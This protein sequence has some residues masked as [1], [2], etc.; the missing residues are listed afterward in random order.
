MSALTDT[1]RAEKTYTFAITTNPFTETNFVGGNIVTS[2]SSD[3]HEPFMSD[4]SNGSK[5]EPVRKVNIAG[6]AE[7]T[8]TIAVFLAGAYQTSKNQFLGICF[9]PICEPDVLPSCVG[10]NYAR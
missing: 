9:I 5:P 1:L 10:E 2:D 4:S 3:T 8:G 6:A 7:L